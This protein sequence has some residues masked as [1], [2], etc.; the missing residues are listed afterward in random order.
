MPA[1]LGAEGVQARKAGEA[2][3]FGQFL[4]AR[5]Q[6]MRL[7]VRH[8]L[9]AVLHAPQ[10]AVRGGK[11]V[12]HGCADP[13]ELREQREPGECL[14]RA[15]RRLAAAR[16]KLLGLHEKL[17]LAD[18]APPQLEVMPGN[19]DA[20]VPFGGVDLPFHRVDVGDGV[21]IEVFPPDI[22][23][24]RLEERIPHWDVAG[25][26]PCLDERRALPIL[27]Q[28]FVIVECGLGRDRRLR[29]VWIGAQPQVGAEHVAVRRALLQDMHEVAGDL[30]EKWG[31]VNGG[32][33]PRAFAAIK[34]DQVDV[35]RIVEFM[36]AV[37]AHRQDDEAGALL[38]GL[39]IREPAASRSARPGAGG[40]ARRR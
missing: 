1:R 26:G 27:A 15:E 11:I 39:G 24:K 16:Y 7:L 20:L 23:L 8:H 2:G 9:Q 30:D 40:S 38:G 17:D 14:A 13:V 29:R 12:A 31:V 28:A 4:F 37:F 36:R 3:E 21:K 22:G 25:H 32:A 19:R 34:H 35:A 6:R 5:G 18:A 10:K 33:E